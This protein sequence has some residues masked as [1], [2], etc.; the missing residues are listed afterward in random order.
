VSVAVPPETFAVGTDVVFALTV[1]DGRL[2]LDLGGR[3]RFDAEAP[4]GFDLAAGAWGVGAWD[5][6]AV[7]GDLKAA[8]RR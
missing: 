7:F 8:P 4:P 1:A 2:R 5:G 6:A 3:T